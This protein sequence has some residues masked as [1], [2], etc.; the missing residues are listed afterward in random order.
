MVLGRY[1]HDRLEG[2]RQIICLLSGLFLMGSGAA[3]IAQV[4]AIE[5]P[6]VSP[7]IRD[8]APDDDFDETSSGLNVVGVGE[9]VYLE[10][11]VLSTEGSGPPIV[12][13]QWALTSRPE[14]SAAALSA[15]SGEMITFRADL[16]GAYEITLTPIDSLAQP[17]E[18]V[19]ETIYASTYVGA[20]VFN[21]EAPPTP[22]I[23]NCGT[24]FCHGET[25]ANP[26]LQGIVQDWLMSNHAQKLQNHLNGNRGSF[27]STSCL[28]CHT[29]GFRDAPQADNGGFDDIARAIG[30]DL[31]QIPPLVADAAD[32]GAENFSFLPTELQNVASI[33]CESCHGP[34]SQHP[35]SLGTV[36]NAIAGA[37]LSPKQCSQCH[38]SGSGFQNKFY[39][40]SASAHPLT[41]EAAEGH[42]SQSA[43]C[44]K[45]HTG[46]GFVDVQ[47]NGLEPTVI[48]VPH[49]VTCATCHDPHFSENAHQLRVVGDFTLDS[50]DTFLDAG[51]GGLCM[52]CHNAR[53]ADADDKALTSRRGAHHGPQTDM[54][55]GV[56][57][58]SFGLPFE[59]ISFHRIAV[60][61]TCVGCHMAETPDVG[62]PSN[63]PPSVG[64]HSYSMRDIGDPNDPD[65][66]VIN[67]VNTCATAG[68]HPS[69][70]TY[71]RLAFGD[72][73]GD[74]MTE[75]VQTEVRGLLSIMRDGILST[76]PGTSEN[77][78]SGRIEI[79]SSD[80]DALEANQRKALYN[81]NFALKDGSFGI[82]NTAYSVQLL[83]RSYFGV[84]GRFIDVDFP[85]IALRGPV[86]VP[87]STRAWRLYDKTR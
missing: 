19:S 34:G 77:P 57:G 36:D 21:T 70:D 51:E 10:A 65:D 11:E 87:S 63:E 72:Y 25:Q 75:G 68:C 37:N 16:I 56:N 61:G 58:V 38:D 1:S 43:S 14:G 5:I 67:V 17:G 86:Q 62:Q 83:Q 26:R 66:D 2:L 59:G 32:T 52:R 71:D 81:Y 18:A 46:E 9:K 79:G 29:L 33:Q 4:V 78:E 53:V 44:V 64:E 48:A 73:D 85:D 27:Y 40:W 24:S 49:S 13:Y 6:A 80:F 69:L 23:P 8:A 7:R 12:D 42:A 55:L 20:G 82:H 47:V 50:G 15:S 3:A 31:N 84:F 74:G 41:P 28:E 30:Y 76:M 39:Q 60:A 45:C 22:S 35:S 54:M